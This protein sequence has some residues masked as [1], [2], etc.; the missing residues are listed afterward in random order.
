MRMMINAMGWA[1]LAA[2]GLLMALALDCGLMCF[3]PD[4][5][6]MP[7][8]AISSFTGLDC[9]LAAFILFLGLCSASLALALFSRIVLT[10][11]NDSA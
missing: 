10:V 11:M 7:A 1:S 6:Q 9:D 4:M 8:P 5:A 2:S 3:R